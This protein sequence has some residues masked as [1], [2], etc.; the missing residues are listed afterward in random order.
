M[1]VRNT[2]SIEPGE[3]KTL[4]FINDLSVVFADLGSRLKIFALMVYLY[5]HKRS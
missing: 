4:N 5:N 1:T 3:I 2:Q